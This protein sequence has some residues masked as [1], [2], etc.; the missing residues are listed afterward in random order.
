MKFFVMAV[1]DRAIDTFG[2]PFCAAAKGAAIRSFGDEVKRVDASNQLN[3]HP[4]DFDLYFLCEYD[5][6]T[7]KFSEGSPEQ[8][9]V[10]KDY[11]V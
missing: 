1:R 8:I 3:K 2:Q 11:A 9:A 7:G 10:G 4:E 6:Q 5:D